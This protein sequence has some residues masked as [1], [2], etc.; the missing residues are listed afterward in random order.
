MAD[1]V[2]HLGHVIGSPSLSIQKDFSLVRPT[3]SG[4]F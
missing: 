3:N 4:S 1:K 2:N